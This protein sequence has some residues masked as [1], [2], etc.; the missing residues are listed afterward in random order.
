MIAANLDTD[1]W[2]HSRVQSTGTVQAEHHTS[3]IVMV[4]IKYVGRVA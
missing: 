2:L 3:A 4:T 1:T